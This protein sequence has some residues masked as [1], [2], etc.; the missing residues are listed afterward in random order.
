MRS[1]QFQLP[2]GKKAIDASCIR[3]PEDNIE[4]WDPYKRGL[5]SVKNW[6]L[7]SAVTYSQQPIVQMVLQKTGFVLFSYKMAQRPPF[8][9]FFSVPTPLI[10]A[11]QNPNY[12]RAGMPWSDW[13]RMWSTLWIRLSRS[14]SS[15]RRHYQVHSTISEPRRC[16]KLCYM[17]RLKAGPLSGAVKASN[18]FYRN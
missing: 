8:D 16:G 10:A 15:R 18:H 6:K 9:E 1:L 4:R 13:Q 7:K 3:K 5:G 11:T 14:F 12:K 17:K 2:S